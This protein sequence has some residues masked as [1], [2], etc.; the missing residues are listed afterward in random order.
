[1]K[2]LHWKLLSTEHKSM[3][4]NLKW[5]NKWLGQRQSHVP[6]VLHWPCVTLSRDQ[7][8]GYCSL[9]WILFFWA[10]EYVL[11]VQETGLCVVVHVKRNHASLSP[12]LRWS[13]EVACYP[14]S[15]QLVSVRVWCEFGTSSSVPS[16]KE[17]QDCYPLFCTHV[18]LKSSEHGVWLSCHIQGVVLSSAIRD[19]RSHAGCKDFS[20]LQCLSA[21]PWSDTKKVQGGFLQG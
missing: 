3:V 9:A 7:N 14:V 4:D 6:A 11:W 19:G 1:M 12:R 16:G 15:C 20:G 8:L 17:L 13:W 18:R 21:V 5:Q 10:A 2:K